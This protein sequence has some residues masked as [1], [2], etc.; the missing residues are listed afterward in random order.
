MRTLLPLMAVGLA[1]AACATTSAG[2]APACSGPRRPANP[3]G[4][5][6]SPDTGAVPPTAGPSKVSPPCAG[7]A[8]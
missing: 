6:L 8:T 3:Y 4:S 1:L 2:K 5:V 7:G